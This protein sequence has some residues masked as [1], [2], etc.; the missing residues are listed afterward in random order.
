MGVITKEF[1]KSSQTLQSRIA[2]TCLKH[3]LDPTKPLA[4]QYGGFLGLWTVG[5]LDSVRALV[6][7]SLKDFEGIIIEAQEDESRRPEADIVS[8]ALLDSVVALAD[9]NLGFLNH[10]VNGYDSET[11]Q[12]ALI[13]KIGPFFAEKVMAKESTD[14]VKVILDS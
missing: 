10:V 7:P 12:A 4:S 5:G 6:I 13:E 8:Q 3:F 2:R 11:M 14:L 1:S 9:D